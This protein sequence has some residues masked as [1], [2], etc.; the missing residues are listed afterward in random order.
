MPPPSGRGGSVYS[1]H[2]APH[3][4]PLHMPPPP[5]PLALPPYLLPQMGPP[6]PCMLHGAAMT[7]PANHKVKEILYKFNKKQKE[8]LI[9]FNFT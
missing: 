1:G 8:H 2:S 4:I 6:P 5:P 3:I 9:F 7:L